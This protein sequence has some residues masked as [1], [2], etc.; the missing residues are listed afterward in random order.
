MLGRR[1]RRRRIYIRWRDLQLH[2]SENCVHIG[3]K[4]GQRFRL[5]S[6]FKFNMFQS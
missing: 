4:E 2:A 6:H 1:R 3:Q 5:M